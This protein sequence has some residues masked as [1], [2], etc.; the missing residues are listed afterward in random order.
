MPRS[1][2]KESEKKC[3]YFV[4][5]VSSPHFQRWIV[6]VVDSGVAEKIV[7]FPS[8]RYAK[9]PI[10]YDELKSRIDISVVNLPIPALISYYISIGLDQFLGRKWR[11]RM[12]KRSLN[13]HKPTFLHFHETQHGA[14]LFNS[15][16]ENFEEARMIKIISTWGSD[17]TLFSRIGE[18]LSKKGAVNR[19]HISEIRK[20]MSWAN[21]L[22][23]EREFEQKDA[24][25][26]GF[27]GQFEAPVYITV[28][29]KENNLI[30][31]EI[32]PSKRKQIIVKGYQH[33]AG[34]ALNCIEALR[35]IASKLLD[36]EV[37]IYSASDS[38]RIQAELFSFE[39]SVKTRILPRLTHEMLLEEFGKSRIYIG[40]STT[41]GLS[42]SMVEAM[43]RGCFPIQ[44]ENSAASIFLTDAHTGFIVDP[45]DISDIAI[46]IEIAL[47]DDNLVDNAVEANLEKLKQEYNYE[48]GIRIIQN[49]YVSKI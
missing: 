42:T 45:W 28:G 15:I 13:R 49:L 17:L 47:T 18:S 8:D 14:Y 36:Y 34:R 43:S 33:D 46:K 39:T 11:S 38:V 21:V 40:L 3:I 27:A 35:R 5:M 44:S 4:G 1:S 2:N 41:D 32:L 37:V 7:V 26:L 23:A 20:A 19:D 31:P 12:L 6:G 10:V 25:R 48:E 29:F 24:L 16:A 30:S 22:T 9:L